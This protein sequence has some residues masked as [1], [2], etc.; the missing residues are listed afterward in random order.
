M[1]SDHRI[2][3][4]AEKLRGPLPGISAQLIMAPVPEGQT[5]RK[6]PIPD[7]TVRQ[8]AVLLLLTNSLNDDEFH[9]DSGAFSADVILTLRSDHL[10]QHSGQI[11]L[12][13][14]RMEA[15]ETPIQAALRETCEEIGLCRQTPQIIG[16]LTSLHVPHTR[17]LIHPV[18]GWLAEVPELT[19]SPWEVQDVF[20]VSL[21]QLCHPGTLQNEIWDL[22]GTRYQVPWWNV[23]PEVPLWGA[24]A[25]ILSEFLSAWNE[26]K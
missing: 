25:M 9:Q 1:V 6:I 10:K 14:G 21:Q 22:R 4:L 12:P 2:H 20:R 23:H 7:D 26:T 8:S 17:H 16:N 24:T 5:L 13:G 3:Q 19:P 18:V 15:G 11:S